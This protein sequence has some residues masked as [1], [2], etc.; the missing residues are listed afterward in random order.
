M[1]VNYLQSIQVQPVQVLRETVYS[2]PPLLAECEDPAQSS[3]SSHGASDRIKKIIE[4]VVCG[5]DDHIR[6]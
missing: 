1:L 6:N 5:V 4:P 2:S 3:D